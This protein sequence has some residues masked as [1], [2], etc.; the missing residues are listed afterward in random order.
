MQVLGGWFFNVESLYLA[1]ET[2]ST[3]AKP[4]VAAGYNLL[5]FY[6]H[7]PKNF[8]IVITT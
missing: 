8:S 6:Y 7:R 1:V 5:Y 2:A 3:Q 4:A